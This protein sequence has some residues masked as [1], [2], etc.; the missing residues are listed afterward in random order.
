MRFCVV[1][2]Y[3]NKWKACKSGVSSHKIPSEHN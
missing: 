3:N 1:P 2:N